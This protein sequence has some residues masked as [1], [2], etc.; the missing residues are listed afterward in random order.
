[1]VMKSND[2]DHAHSYNMAALLLKRL[3]NKKDV[4]YAIKRTEDKV[5]VLRFGVESDMDCLKLDD[6]VSLRIYYLNTLVLFIFV[7][8]D[9]IRLKIPFS[10]AMMYVSVNCLLV[11]QE[12]GVTF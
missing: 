3:T 12:S 6:I 9:I 5:L 1:M 11:I 4:D 7:L 8:C 2:W 10:L